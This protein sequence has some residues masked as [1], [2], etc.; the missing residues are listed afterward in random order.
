LSNHELDYVV[1]KNEIHVHH[2]D[3]GFVLGN[4]L[5]FIENSH[6]SKELFD[7]TMTAIHKFLNGERVEGT[8]G[9]KELDIN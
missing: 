6:L 4:F 3:M 9:N 5:N 7:L 8:L 2:S 1:L